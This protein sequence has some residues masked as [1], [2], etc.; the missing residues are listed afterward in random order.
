LT[1]GD[2]IVQEAEVH[3]PA[4]VA[5][6]GV[7]IPL[8]P[9]AQFEAELH[10]VLGSTVGEV[11]EPHP[12]TIA[13]DATVGEAAELMTERRVSRLPVVDGGRLVGIISRAD[14]VRELLR[15]LGE[16]AGS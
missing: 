7:V 13:P 6:L 14:I 5:I 9:P 3:P 10:K 1:T 16:E 4:G 8:T 15:D 12:V 11:M 2:L